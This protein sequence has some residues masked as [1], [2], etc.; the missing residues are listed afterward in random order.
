MTFSLFPDQSAETAWSRPRGRP[1][2]HFKSKRHRPRHQRRRPRTL[3]ASRSPPLPRS[4]LSQ[5]EAGPPS[6]ATLDLPILTHTKTL[7]EVSRFRG[8][9]FQMRIQIYFTVTAFLS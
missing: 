6:Q 4:H 8:K 9:T 5:A 7:E 3:F 1:H 2:H